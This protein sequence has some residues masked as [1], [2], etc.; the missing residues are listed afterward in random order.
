MR[1]AGADPT[2]DLQTIWMEEGIKNRQINEELID[3][4]EKLR[5]NYSVGVLTNLTFSRKILDEEM[6]LYSH[7]D[8]VALSCVEHLKKPDHAFYQ[9]ALK[10]AGVKTQEAIYIDDKES[11]TTPAEEI[12]IK[13]FY[14]PTLTTKNYCV[15]C[16][17]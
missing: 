6:N 16:S 3:I 11:C 4:I 2:L 13:V 14:T 1:S 15:I 8:Y 5:E 17:N 12:G 10:R 7:F 9:L